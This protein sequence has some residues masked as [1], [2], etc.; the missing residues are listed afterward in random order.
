MTLEEYYNNPNTCLECKKIIEVQ[1]DKVGKNKISYALLKKFCTRECYL[2]NIRNKSKNTPSRRHNKCE[3]GGVKKITSKVCKK[4][5]GGNVPISE[6]TYKSYKDRYNDWWSARVP[7]ARNA[8]RVYSASDKPK[9]CM[10]CGYDK[11]Y[12]VCHIKA[13]S[14]FDDNTLIKEINDLSNLVALCPNC[15][16]EFDNNLLKL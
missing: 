7:I 14:E 2:I 13:V 4:C 6:S 15:H 10:N 11:H 12:Q 8:R 3:C 5:R 9:R 1:K 16:W